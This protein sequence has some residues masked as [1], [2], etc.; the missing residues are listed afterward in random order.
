M[1]QALKDHGFQINLVRIWLLALRLNWI[2]IFNETRTN[3][4]L[5]E[6]SANSHAFFLLT[7]VFFIASLTGW[8]CIC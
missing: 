5:N 4:T 1:F 6:L 8:V 7:D 2:L 3:V